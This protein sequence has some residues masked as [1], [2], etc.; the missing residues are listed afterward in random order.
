MCSL[1]GHG[2]VTKSPKGAWD[3]RSLFRD[4]EPG[5]RGRRPRRPPTSACR[6]TTPPGPAPSTASGP[7]PAPAAA[8]LLTRLGR[9]PNERVSVSPA[10][11]ARILRRIDAALLPLMLSVYFLQALDKATLS[12]ASIFG[13]IDDTH[14][15]GAQ[16]SWL[17]SVVFVAQLVMQLLIS[18]ALVKLPI[19]KFTSVMVLAWGAVL[20]AMASARNFSQLMAVRF[21]LGAF[22][23]S[24]GP[25]FVAITQMWWRRRQAA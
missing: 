3:E 25:S 13:L 22:E 17:G 11:D 6:R 12:Y 1:F 14:L 20:A 19:A 2:F 23:A 15:V 16:F 24:I 4:G 9:S 10:D 5:T 18:L 7:R 8:A 21:F